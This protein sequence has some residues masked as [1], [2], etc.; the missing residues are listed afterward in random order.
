MFEAF[1]KLSANPFR[2]TPDPKFCFRH[3]S[4]NQAYAYLQ[5]ALR[6]GEGFILVTGRTGIGKTTLAEVFLGEI[7]QSEVVAARVAS[8][9]VETADLLRVVAYAYGIDVAGVDKA[10]VVLQLEQFFVRQTRAGRRVLLIVD[11]AQSLPHSALEE[12]RLLADLQMDSRPLVQLFLV[13][14][15][16]LRDVMREPDMEQFQQRVIGACHLEPLDLE[17]TKS[18]IEHRLRT[19]GWKGDPELSGAAVAVIFYYSKGVPRHVNKICTR[20]LLHGMLEE[21]HHLH[22][23]DVLS[24]AAELRA[25]QLA[26]ME[27]G[28]SGAADA[29]QG[30]LLEELETGASV[31]ELALRMDPQEVERLKEA[32]LSAEP[33]S[34]Q[35]SGG[36]EDALN[37]GEPHRA[38]AGRDDRAFPPEHE[39]RPP[40]SERPDFRHRSAREQRFAGFGE[41][42]G[43]ASRR[44][45]GRVRSAA[46]PRKT[47]H[48]SARKDW[49]QDAVSRLKVLWH[50][51]S[52]LRRRLSRLGQTLI[53]R[54]GQAARMFARLSWKGKLAV[55]VAALLL[56]NLITAGLMTDLLDD[57]SE[58]KSLLVGYPESAQNIV[59]WEQSR[60]AMQ[61]DESGQTTALRPDAGGSAE[62]GAVSRPHEDA[63]DDWFSNIAES[64]DRDGLIVS[65][66]R[67]VPAPHISASAAGD[68][69][70]QHGAVGV[71]DPA[72]AAAEAGAPSVAARSVREQARRASPVQQ[73][74]SPSDAGP[75]QYSAGQL[76]EEQIAQSPAEGVS[77]AKVADTTV[78]V[79]SPPAVPSS[80]GDGYPQAQQ[81]TPAPAVSR[82][83]RV[84]DLLSRGNEALKRD[85]LL[86]PAGD[87][88]YKYYQQALI[89]DPG[90]DEALFGIERVVARYL[91]LARKAIEREDK[92]K[93][94]RYVERGLRINPWDQRLLD[95]SD[96]LN[97][98]VATVEAEVPPPVPVEEPPPEAGLEPQPADF[99]SRVKAFFSKGQSAE[100]PT[101]VIVEERP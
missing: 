61:S 22:K 18:Y 74:D 96:S 27:A 94:N 70:A 50:E 98:P 20:V 73:P 65:A 69:A 49:K 36:A 100:Q 10:T 1:Y 11:E 17:G 28:E 93:A 46:S 19:A 37:R 12:L 25:E 75:S 23:A 72:Q 15:E 60:D 88:A 14:Q 29:Q 101:E 64:W 33:P 68:A 82:Q 79:V 78:A 86:I 4:Y 30:Q 76:P 3:P 35:A 38:T 26:P 47:T 39:R 58:H 51:A 40:D 44:R 48:R 80:I 56:V 31:A 59:S 87:S 53:Q 55:F 24:V 7:Q 66:R 32:E 92:E 6:L 91:A 84:A 13:G 2:L 90:N 57:G 52:P 77:V 83:Q 42:P 81:G 63:E 21:K 62:G 89:L 99:I 16:K 45:P 9:N 41:F 34:P 54:A 8:A 5:Y 85:R 97:A 43:Q 95:L 67:R 71:A